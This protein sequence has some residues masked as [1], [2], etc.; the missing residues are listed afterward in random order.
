MKK[1][2]MLLLLTVIFSLG[3]RC[4]YAEPAI[5]VDVDNTSVT[6]G[7]TFKLS[8]NAQT[9]SLKGMQFDIEYDAK[10]VECQS[11]TLTDMLDEAIASGIEVPSPGK[12]TVLAAF[13][14]ETELSGKICD[15]VF[16]AIGGD[17]KIRITNIKLMVDGER[18]PEPDMEKQIKVIGQNTES[19]SGGTSWGS[20]GGSRTKP[21]NNDKNAVDKN[22]TKTDNA[23]NNLIADDEKNAMSFDD[24]DGHWA[25]DAI[26]FILKKKIVSGIGENKFAPDQAVTRAELACMIAKTLDLKNKTEN[27]YVDVEDDAW[28]TEGILTCVQEG[29]MLGADNEFRPNDKVT[30][31]ETAAVLLR[32]AKYLK[33]SLTQADK[34]PEFVDKD[35]IA[36]W[37][38]NAV[39]ELTGS[40]FIN[41]FEDGTFRAKAE[42]T[43]AQTAVL[44]KKLL[45]LNVKSIGE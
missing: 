39:S 11:S 30:R 10:A 24:I 45:D 26:V 9:D 6:A 31:E 41:G 38:I 16:K 42:T 5:T 28:S 3:V 32:A 17:T 4:A 8:V 21:T 7:E 35:D 2:I 13:M 22:D 23:E 20:S 33:L 1:N 34:V 36:D 18:K 40:N 43:R 37:A 12:V 27:T 25:S 29:I 19:P 44:L 15:V 14:E